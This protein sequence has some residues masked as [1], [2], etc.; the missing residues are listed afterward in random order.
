MTSFKSKIDKKSSALRNEA[1]LLTLDFIFASI[2]IG[3]FFSIL[4]SIMLT[5][6][7]VEVTQYVSYSTAR[8]FYA[9]HW[10]KE[11]QTSLAT[12]K[13]NELIANPAIA[14][15]YQNGWF[16]LKGG[17]GVQDWNQ[18]YE[19]ALNP[20]QDS[21]NFIGSR[22]QLNAKILE[23]NVPLIGSTSGLDDAFKANVASYLNREP[24]STECL[25]F[26]NKENRFA[27]IQQLDASYKNSLIRNYIVMVDNGC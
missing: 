11:N 24:T 1:G 18:I 12:K 20:Q 9:A 17:P 2:F 26:M 10:D 13:F 7:V 21:N 27:A 16:E 3:A 5:L 19:G 15:F 22:L 23:F 8:N 14:S 25:D 4:F 6:S